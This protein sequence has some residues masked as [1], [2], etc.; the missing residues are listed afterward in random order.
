MPSEEFKGRLRKLREAQDLSLQ[1][2]A[3]AVGASRAHI[4]DLEQGRSTN[5]SF[6]LLK[7]LAACFKVSVSDLVGENVTSEPQ[8]SRVVGMFRDLKELSDKDLDVIQS[9][10]DRLKKE[11]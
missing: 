6:E 5:P 10:V 2:V 1:D 3:T 8:D 4:W 7:K 11:P 9:L